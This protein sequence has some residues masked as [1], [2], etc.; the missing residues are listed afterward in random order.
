MNFCMFFFLLL[1]ENAF[2]F[3][4]LIFPSEPIVQI[5]TGWQLFFSRATQLPFSCCTSIL[6][7]AWHDN[8]LVLYECEILYDQLLIR[9]I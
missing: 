1:C 2:C 9:F 8:L 4:S 6:N 5:L 7:I 3:D